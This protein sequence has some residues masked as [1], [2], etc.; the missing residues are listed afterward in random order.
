MAA[1]K[2]NT[3]STSNTRKPT[4]RR[5]GTAD[6]TERRRNAP[7]TSAE[8]AAVRK[9]LRMTMYYSKPTSEKDFIQS[10]GDTFGEGALADRLTQKYGYSNQVRQT[11][12]IAREVWR[13]SKESPMRKPPKR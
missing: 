4:V 6:T 7:L 2:R 11:N 8:V 3:S 12:K 1:K 10:L 9:D 5:T 13:A